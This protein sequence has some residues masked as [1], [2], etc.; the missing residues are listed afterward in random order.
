MKAN[1]D[2][3]K[4][5]DTLIFKCDESRDGDVSEYD[6]EVQIINVDTVSMIYLSGYRNRNDDIKFDDVIA[7]VD[8]SQPKIKLVDAP[9]KGNFIVFE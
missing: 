5:G 8:L 9:Y 7:K 2:T 4:V 1:K 3:I 6:G